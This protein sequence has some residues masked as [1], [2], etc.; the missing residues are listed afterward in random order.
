MLF[1][2]NG[3]PRICARCN[4]LAVRQ[5]GGNWLCP[6]CLQKRRHKQS[7]TANQ[8][9]CGCGNVAMTGDTMC[10]MCRTEA[11]E[12][13]RQLTRLLDKK[14]GTRTSRISVG[15]KKIHSALSDVI[16]ISCGSISYMLCFANN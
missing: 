4:E 15:S 6:T 13:D 5:A 9:K 10:G 3:D 2:K 14:N 11:E 1:N 7:K 8:P 16:I 12:T